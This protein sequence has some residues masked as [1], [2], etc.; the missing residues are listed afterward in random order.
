MTRMLAPGMESSMK[1]RNLLAAAIGPLSAATS[2]QASVDISVSPTKNMK[3]AGGICT[4]RA[5]NAILNATDLANMLAAGDVKVTTGNGAVTIIVSSSF[6]WTS[7][8]R[9][10]LDAIDTVSFAAPVDVA[11]PGAVTVTTNDGGTGGDLIFL[12]GGKL[13]FRDL[14]SGLIINGNSYALAS[15]IATLAAGVAANPSGSYA[16]PTDYDAAPDGTYADAPI[17]T[18]AGTFEGLGHA[19]SNLTISDVKGKTVRNAGLFGTSSGT[20]RDI[21]VLNANITVGGKHGNYAGALVSQNT[22]TIPH[23][24]AT[25]SVV[26]TDFGRG[27]TLGGMVAVNKGIIRYSHSPTTSN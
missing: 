25:S 16:L 19:I 20:I 22:G 10:T 24:F 9:L 18:F 7:S 23:A 21:G 17:K 8:S 26:Y 27:T 13:D 3:C 14:G 4:P 12:D 6:S 1:A 5:A 15:D 2:A 11:G